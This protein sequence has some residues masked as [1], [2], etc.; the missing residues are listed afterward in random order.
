MPAACPPPL[1]SCLFTMLQPLP[2]FPPFEPRQLHSAA[3]LPAGH[4]PES[5][6]L[7]ALVLLVHDDGTWHMVHGSMGG[8][9][10]GRESTTVL[11]HSPSSMVRCSALRCSAVLCGALRCTVASCVPQCPAMQCPAVC[12]GVP[13]RAMRCHVLPCGAMQCHAVPCAAMQ[14]HVLPRL[15]V[16]GRKCASGVVVEAGRERGKAAA[17]SPWAKGLPHDTSAR[18]S[19]ITQV[20]KM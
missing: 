12:C 18:G 16:V 5:C 1:V 7:M 17:A 9:P 2:P 14:C 13:C 11:S 6:L 19:R 15:D 4:V 10:Y 8:T 3:A 20:F